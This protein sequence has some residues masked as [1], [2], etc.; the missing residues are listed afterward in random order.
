MPSSG[1]CRPVLF[2]LI[3]P[4]AT[5]STVT[6]CVIRSKGVRPHC[7][8]TWNTHGCS[9]RSERHCHPPTGQPQCSCS[10]SEVPITGKRARTH[11][12]AP[13]S[14]GSSL[15]EPFIEDLGSPA[16]QPSAHGLYLA[17]SI[18]TTACL[19]RQHVPELG[20]GA[21]MV[22]VTALMLAGTLSAYGHPSASALAAYEAD[23]AV[24]ELRL[25]LQENLE[26]AVA[27]LIAGTLARS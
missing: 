27:T 2:C 14:A 6:P 15:V 5:S 7:G 19:I 23:P 3:R 9:G 13:G 11:Q 17:T 16:T 18:A 12:L 4:H 10:C 22:A 26:Y 20:Q 25:D 21:R 24:M 1:S 8:R